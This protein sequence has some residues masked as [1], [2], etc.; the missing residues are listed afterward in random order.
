MTYSISTTFIGMAYTTSI[1]TTV[2]GMDIPKKLVRTVYFDKSC[3]SHSVKIV[4]FGLVSNSIRPSII[5]TVGQ[6]E[7]AK[8][9]EKYYINLVVINKTSTKG[10]MYIRVC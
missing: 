8:F 2:V 10:G 9:F 6:A 3:N 7:N 4:D 5:V 1:P